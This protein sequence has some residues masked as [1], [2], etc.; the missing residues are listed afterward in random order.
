MFS[1]GFATRK[2]LAATTYYVD[3][4]TGAGSDS[5]LGIVSAPWATL[6]H[7]DSLL[8]T[9]YQ[10]VELK[11]PDGTW[12]AVPPVWHGFLSY[13]PYIE[14][15]FSGSNASTLYDVFNGHN[16]TISGASWGDGGVGLTFLSGQHVTIPDFAS[17]GPT[18]AGAFIVEQ[19]NADTGDDIS[20]GIGPVGNPR[21]GAYTPFSGTVYW[22]FGNFSGGRVSFTPS[23]LAGQQT[24]WGFLAGGNYQAIYQNVTRAAF[25]NSNLTFT[26]D[27]NVDLTLGEGNTLQSTGMT[28]NGL[29]ITDNV[30]ADSDYLTLEGW[31]THSSPT[32]VAATSI[33]SSSATLNGLNGAFAAS[34]SAFWYGTTSATLTPSLTPLSEFPTGWNGLDTGALVANSTF[35]SS[36]GS[37]ASSTPYYFVAWSDVGGTWYPGS[38][39]QFT[40]AVSIPGAPI[41][42]SVSPGGGPSTGGT[43]ITI[44]GTNFT[45]AT[46][47]DFGSS[48]AA[49]FTVV[50]DTS[51]T[52]TSPA[53]TT[54]GT[55]NV[56]ITTPSATSA[57]SDADEFTYALPSNGL[58]QVPMMGWD[59]WRAYGV[60]TTEAEVKANADKI[61]TNGMAA[62]GYQFV[63]PTDN[64]ATGRDGGGNLITNTGLY[65]DGMASL[66]AYIHGKG[67]LVGGYLAPGS[68]VAGCNGF[69]GSEGHEATDASLLASFGVDY[70]MYDNCFAFPSDNA[71][72]AA[73]ASMGAALQ[74]SGRNIS[75]LVSDPF[76]PNSVTWVSDAGGNA[77]WTNPDLGTMDWTNMTSILD[78]QYGLEVYTHPG[79]W[80]MPDFLGVGDGLLT[81]TEG[82]SNFSLWAILA[83]PLWASTDLTT[84]SP[85]TITTLTNP[86]VIA[87]DQDSAGIQGKR[88]SRITCGD[89]NCE[90]YARQL[91]DGAWAVVLFNRSSTSQSIS[92]TWSMFGQSGPFAGRDLWAHSDLGTLATG[93]TTTVPSHGVAMLKLSSLTPPVISS[94]ASSTTQTTAII[95]WTTDLTAS[96][97]VNYGLT[98]AYGTAS[99]SAALVT[100]HSISLSGLTAATNYHFQV[101]GA[102]SDGM[103]STSTDLTFTTAAAPDATPPTV[104]LSS[105]TASSMVSGSVTLK[106]TSSD[107]V[108][109]TGV[110]FSIDGINTGTSGAISPYSVTWDSTTESNGSHTISAV[111]SDAAGNTATSSETV[112]VSNSV[113][114]GGASSSGFGVESG[115]GGYYAPLPS[116]PPAAICQAGDRFNTTT[117]APCPSVSAVIPAAPALSPLPSFSNDLNVGKTDPQVKLLQEFLNSHGFQVALY[118]NGSPGHETAYFGVLTR[119][120]LKHYQSFHGIKPASGYFGPI[121]RK[122]IA[123]HS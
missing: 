3:A 98:S 116:I 19:T 11:Y 122:Y 21:I 63:N 15:T 58:A 60:G 121:T 23:S 85:A 118:G 32:T 10:N 56:T 38:V 29:L 36:A 26:A 88:V 89:A 59:S 50:S 105:P 112:I 80:N 48:A 47:V 68:G 75:F 2:A 123:L 65:P 67:L 77:V 84:A 34:D 62:A 96:S 54:P 117:G 27:A 73:Y 46:A 39:L 78:N 100:S 44:T 22:D 16:G 43:A 35:S 103:V 42:S 53:T 91:S 37:L 120:A 90:A 6:A 87:V 113:S 74:A 18:S 28:Q 101:G 55:T 93:Y 107:N 66:D 12:H 97:T 30:L 79:R 104:S 109:V 64:W 99:T 115:G 82:E 106:A 5:N 13:Y 49:G 61:A 76:D 20:F 52:A 111:A 45:G 71:A 9:N 102:N 17:F 51:I 83:A 33:T 24:V 108:G 1:G 25:Q 86:D 69:P 95:S 4:I 40:T 81:D 72:R 110:Q 119:D 57:I 7:A 8:A 41:V 92:A 14:G 70:L 31:L 114:S 94:I